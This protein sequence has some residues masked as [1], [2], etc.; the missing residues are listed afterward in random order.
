MMIYGNDRPSRLLV[1]SANFTRRGLDNFNL[2]TSVL[3]HGLASEA[4]FQDAYD[5]FETV[6]HNADGKS[7]SV[8][9]E[10]YKDESYLRYAWYRLLDMTGMSTF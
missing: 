5:Y 7:F 8:G 3:V 2:E 4:V 1:G 9:Y 6:W 10:H